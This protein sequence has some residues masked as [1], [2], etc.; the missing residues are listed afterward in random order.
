MLHRFFQT[1]LKS[2]I[3]PNNKAY[4][5]QERRLT[6]ESFASLQKYKQQG[7]QPVQELP[8]FD[9]PFFGLLFRRSSLVVDFSKFLVQH[10]KEYYLQFIFEE[11]VY[12][13]LQYTKQFDKQSNILYSKYLSNKASKRIDLTPD[14]AE[15]LAKKRMA[16][17]IDGSFFDEVKEMVLGRLHKLWAQF[18]QTYRFAGL[19]K[20]DK[21]LTKKQVKKWESIASYEI[22]RKKRLE[23]QLSRESFNDVFDNTVLLES[24]HNYLFEREKQH[25]LLFLLEARRFA[26]MD[27]ANDQVATHLYYEFIAGEAKKPVK[28]STATAKTVQRALV[29]PTNSMFVSAAYEVQTNLEWFEFTDFINMPSKARRSATM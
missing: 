15:K 26:L 16:V 9:V 11:D 8:K 7:M 2:P 18:L 4:R 3:C 13:H 21:T 27:D 5:D 24:F 6:L 14:V 22:M 28:I 12:R 19:S 25:K 29:S 17:K 10:G 1:F 23:N 20:K